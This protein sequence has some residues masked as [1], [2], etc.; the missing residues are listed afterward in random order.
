MRIV[1]RKDLEMPFLTPQYTGHKQGKAFLVEQDIIWKDDYMKK[2]Q[3]NSK[4]YGEEASQQR[5]L[6]GWEK[7]FEEMQDPNWCE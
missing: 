4:Q 6:Q 7:A 3:E 5:Y 1:P 2:G